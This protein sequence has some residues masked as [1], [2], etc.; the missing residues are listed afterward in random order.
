MTAPL[1]IGRLSPIR[2]PMTRIHIVPQ[3]HPAVVQHSAGRHSTVREGIRLGLTVGAATWLWLAG[4]DFVRGEPFQTFHFLGGLAAFSLVHFALCLAYGFTIISAVHASMKEP[5]IMFGII[6]SAILFQAA[7]VIVT[8]MLANIGIGQ[9]AWGK[10]FVG[11]A[12]AACLTF[13]LISRNHSL[14]NLFEAAE[15][16]QKD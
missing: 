5:T 15:A 4:F 14:K 7:A 11:N 8:A 2:Y 13:V 16:L 12:I 10:F 9:L 1:D 3:P 6:F